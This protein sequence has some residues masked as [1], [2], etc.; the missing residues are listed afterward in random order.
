MKRLALLLLA[1]LPLF[2]RAAEVIP[3]KPHIYVEGH[4]SLTAE[5]D[6]M[7][8]SIELAAVDMDVGV[9]KDDIDVRSTKLIQKLL[10]LG[11]DLNDI[12]T[13][14]VRVTPQFR[15]DNGKQVPTGMQASRQIDITLV[16]LATY[17]DLMEALFDVKVDQILATQFQLSTS[18]SLKDQALAAALADA[19]TRAENLAKSQGRKLGDVWSISEFNTRYSELTDL[20]PSAAAVQSNGRTLDE[21][22][23]TG[24][25]IRE[26]FQPGH[27]TGSATV[28][29]VYL[30]K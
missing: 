17:P 3:D 25:R 18:D 30:L 24:S 22:T 19:K 7:R 14:N 20:V 29:V 21:V 9:A 5:P 8:I 23:I 26:P 6:R 27:I 10:D 11:I 15:F 4:A 12:T 2:S 28:Y 13:A 16:N 1:C